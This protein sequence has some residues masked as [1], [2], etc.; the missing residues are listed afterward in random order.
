MAPQILSNI[1]CL[2][3]CSMFISWPHILYIAGAIGGSSRS[4]SLGWWATASVGSLSNKLDQLHG[5]IHSLELP[6]GPG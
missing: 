4:P 1:N 5:A 6:E 3:R 2:G